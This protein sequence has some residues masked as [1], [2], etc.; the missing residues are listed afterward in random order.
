M[1]I[2]HQFLLKEVGVKPRIGWHIDPFGHSN[3][4]ARLFAEMG[5]DAIFFARA[6]FQDAKKRMNESKME[7]LW[8][9]FFNHIGKRGQI[10]AHLMVNDTYE[11]PRHFGFDDTKGE[12]V[13]DEGPFVNDTTLTSFNADW[14]SAFFIELVKNMS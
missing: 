2:G 4:N 1:M 12:F 3:T 11:S 7:W 13:F 6:D 10:L 9:P 8:R 14:K 5:F